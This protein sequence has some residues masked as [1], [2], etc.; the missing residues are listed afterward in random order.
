MEPFSAL[1]ALCSWNSLVTGEFPSQRSV[2]RSFDVFFDPR[3]NKRLSK[4]SWR[5]LF[6]TPSRSL[7]RRC[8][9]LSLKFNPKST[10]DNKS[11]SVLV[12]AVTLVHQALWV[13]TS[14]R[15]NKTIHFHVNNLDSS[16]QWTISDIVSLTHFRCT[17]RKMEIITPVIYK[18]NFDARPRTAVVS[19]RSIRR[20]II[21]ILNAWFMVLFHTL[22]KVPYTRC[23]PHVSYFRLWEQRGKHTCV[24]GCFLLI[25]EVPRYC[26][27]S[28]HRDSHCFSC[29][30]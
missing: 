1:L 27:R 20:T 29:S 7:W 6:E 24:S 28:R 23:Q 22:K 26:A 12:I 10:I 5:R 14:N 15:G 18:Y 19:A 30:H 8:N 17:R 25:H 4:Q 13:L 21:D 9:V 2:T 11:T 16:I 3:L